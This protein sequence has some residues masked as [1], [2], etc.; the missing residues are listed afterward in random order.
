[1]GQTIQVTCPGTN[2]FYTTDGSEPTTNSDRVSNIAGNIG[3]IHWFNTTNDLSFLRVKAFIDTTNATLTAAGQP[4]S[5]ATIGTPPDFNPS[6]QAGIG[7]T[8]VIPVVCNLA[9]G[10]QIESFQFRLEIAPVNNPNTPVFSPLSIYPTNDFVPVITIAQ[11]GS[12]ASYSAAPYAN[13]ITNGLAVSAI[14]DGNNVLF[15][16]YA[17]VSL[18]AVQIP[19]TANEGDTY[20]LNVLYPSATADGFNTPVPLTA[21]P[22]VTIVVTNLPYLVGDSASATSGSWYNAGTFGDGNLDNADVN[23]AFDAASGL[24]TPYAFSDAFNAMDAYPV[25][26]AGSVGGDGQIRFLDWNTIL[27]RSLR[28]DTNNW[29]REWSQ[30][31][32]LIDF[33]TNLVSHGLTEPATKAATKGLSEVNPAAPWYRPALLGADSV[34]DVAANSTVLV[35]V[36]AQLADGSSLSGLQFRVVV[37]PQ[38]SAPALS[39]APQLV[40]ASG[41]TPPYITHSFQAGETAFGWSVGSCDFASLSSNFLGWVSFTVPTNAVTGQTY[42]VSF[43]NADGAPD[44]NNQYTN[45]E[46]RSATVAVNASAPPASICSDEWKINFFGSTTNPAAADNADPDGDGVP[47]WMEFLA[48]TDPTNPNSKLVLNAAALQTIKGQRNISVQWLTAPGRAYA[49][50]WNNNLAGGAWQTLGTVSGNGY[51]TNCADLTPTNS[52]RYYRLSVLP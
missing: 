35:P 34:S 33:T 15:K 36:Y 22:P 50:Q 3:S 18:L 52:T 42:Q 21:L 49:V 40:L 1:M 47:N 7:A 39:E 9:P 27:N 38:A 17:V 10:Q 14:G 19:Y 2:V 43:L 37:T 24:R 8:V 30:D 12:V 41:V 4:V 20:S 32:F 31:G 46:T 25:D 44:L 45:L 51:T 29:D 48:G 28:L 11:N 13:G 6:L 5:A 16:N 26:T 23:Q